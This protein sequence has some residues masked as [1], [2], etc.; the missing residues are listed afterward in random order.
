MAEDFLVG[1]E[2]AEDLGGDKIRPFIWAKKRPGKETSKKIEI[3]VNSIS[4]FDYVCY[5]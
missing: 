5:N 3:E 1:V 4:I 2:G